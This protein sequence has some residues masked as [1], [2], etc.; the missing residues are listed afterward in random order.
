VNDKHLEEAVSK[1]AECRAD[2]IPGQVATFLPQYEEVCSLNHLG[3]IKIIIYSVILK[4]FHLGM[5]ISYSY[6]MKRHKELIS[7]DGVLEE[8]NRV[9]FLVEF[10]RTN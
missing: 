10:V 5:R 6:N 4:A 3:L 1:L 8:D 7:K 2:Y 9:A